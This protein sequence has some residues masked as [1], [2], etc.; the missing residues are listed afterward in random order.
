LNVRA[1]TQ[2]GPRGVELTASD[3]VRVARERAL[4]TTAVCVPNLDLHCCHSGVTVVLQWRY[5]GV[6]VVLQWCS[7]IVT[8][9]GLTHAG[10]VRERASVDRVDGM[11]KYG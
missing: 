4:V 7:S 2:D 5:T 9:V 6:T 11:R 10:T 1:C 8:V 3:G